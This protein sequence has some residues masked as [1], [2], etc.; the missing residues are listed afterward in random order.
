MEDSPVA[1]TV[2]TYVNSGEKVGNKSSSNTY[3]GGCDGPRVLRNVREE[4]RMETS[5]C[6]EYIE[7]L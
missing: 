7:P 5:P 1:G 6:T 3:V 2:C 4:T